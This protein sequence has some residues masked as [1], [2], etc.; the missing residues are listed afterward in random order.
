MVDERDQS[1]R[2]VGAGAA[3]GAEA[4]TGAATGAEATTGAATGAEATT[5]AAGAIGVGSPYG[6]GSARMLGFVLA[7]A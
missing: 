7:S 3:T 4:T 6:R 1:A 2:R 5:G